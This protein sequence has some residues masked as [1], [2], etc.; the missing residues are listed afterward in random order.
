MRDLV[1]E[2]KLKL[3]RNSLHADLASDQKIFPPLGETMVAQAEQILGFQLSGT[4]RRIYA[5]VA[6]GGFGP[7]YGLLGLKDGARNESGEDVV[8]LYKEF[9][10][11][12]PKDPLWSWPKGLLPVGHLGCGM[13]CCVDATHSD[14]PVI[15]FEPN[16]HSDGATWTDS[17]IPLAKST[18]EWLLAWLDGEDLLDKLF[19]ESGA[20]T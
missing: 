10:R 16:P 8:A 7:G 4:L 3:S 12:D 2:L 14:G 11:N 19:N 13:F 15:W 20:D 5:E 6:N 9:S 17:F 18:N 1:A